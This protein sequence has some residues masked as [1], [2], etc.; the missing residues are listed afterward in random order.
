MTFT[1][2]TN[3]V[4]GAKK[5]GFVHD[6][7]GKVF[8]DD[9][10]VKAFLQIRDQNA[11]DRIPDSLFDLDCD[12]YI[13]DDGKAYA[14]YDSYIG[15]KDIPVAWIRLIPRCGTAYATKGYGLDD[16]GI[17]WGYEYSEENGL[18]I[19]V[20]DAANR[21][22]VESEEEAISECERCIADWSRE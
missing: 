11:L 18:R 19:V 12:A 5:A 15:G 7:T 9:N 13:G 16:Y 1:K 2:I 4:Y 22:E 20:T 8:Y 10:A 6:G 17:E 3:E 14:V 21:E